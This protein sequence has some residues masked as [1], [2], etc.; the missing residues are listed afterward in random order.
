[1]FYEHLQN[2][3]SWK[4]DRNRKKDGGGGGGLSTPGEQRVGRI[5]FG[6]WPVASRPKQLCSVCIDTAAVKI[7]EQESSGTQTQAI[8]N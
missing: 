7:I 2:K 1:M 5:D 4:A 8:C 6:Q 3:N